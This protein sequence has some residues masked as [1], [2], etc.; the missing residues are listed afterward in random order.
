MVEVIVPCTVFKSLVFK[1]N[2]RAT[3]S[4][5]TTGF[6]DQPFNKGKNKCQE[7]KLTKN[8]TNAIVIMADTRI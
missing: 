5:K 1:M 6:M 7:K 3:S 8:W 2:Q 4:P